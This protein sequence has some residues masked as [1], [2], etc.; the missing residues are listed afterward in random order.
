[1]APRWLT[2]LAVATAALI[3]ALNMKLVFDFLS[4]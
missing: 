3:I 2:A 1:V 4:G